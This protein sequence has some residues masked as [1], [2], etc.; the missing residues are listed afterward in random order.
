MQGLR[1]KN[2]RNRK[3]KNIPQWS[4]K[5][6]KGDLRIDSGRMHVHA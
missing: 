4:L 6:D 1:I 5:M 2:W 3:L